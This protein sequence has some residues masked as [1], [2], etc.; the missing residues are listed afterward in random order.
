MDNLIILLIL[1]ITIRFNM[2]LKDIKEQK[3]NIN[4]IEDNIFKNQNTNTNNPKKAGRPKMEAKKK[5]RKIIFCL[6]EEEYNRLKEMSAD[7]SMANFIRTILRE[8]LYNKE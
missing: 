6:Y 7:E 8:K 5:T 4:L 2:S 1:L 3:N